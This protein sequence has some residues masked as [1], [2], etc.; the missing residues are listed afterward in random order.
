MIHSVGIPLLSV[1]LVWNLSSALMFVWVCVEQKE[2]REGEEKQGRRIKNTAHMSRH[3]ISQLMCEFHSLSL[4]PDHFNK[5]E[6]FINLKS[7]LPSLDFE[8]GANK[9]SLG[10][11][12]NPHIEIDTT[13]SVPLRRVRGPRVPCPTTSSFSTTD[14]LEL[15]HTWSRRLF[16]VV[17]VKQR[18]VALTDRMGKK[19]KELVSGL[20]ITRLSEKGK[21]L[22]EIGWVYIWLCDLVSRWIKGL[23]YAHTEITFEVVLVLPAT[24]FPCDF[25]SHFYPVWVHLM[26]QNHKFQAKKMFF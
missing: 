21:H 23:I 5:Q 19:K 18:K 1:G 26:F 25:M 2:K 22:A 14:A 7:F 16:S 11:S 10:A 3:I 13:Q 6:Y 20:T 17:I 15:K 8:S 4:R 12:N 9:V 24:K